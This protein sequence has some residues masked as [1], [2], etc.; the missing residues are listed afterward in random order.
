MLL[1]AVGLFFREKIR[2]PISR[3]NFIRLVSF[4]S[5]LSGTALLV[6]VLK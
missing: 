1:P 3:S 2:L 4:I 5:L 6:K